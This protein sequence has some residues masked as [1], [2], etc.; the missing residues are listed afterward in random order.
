M[1]MLYSVSQLRYHSMIHC[2]SRL[3]YYLLGSKISATTH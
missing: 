3:V 1:R 2:Y